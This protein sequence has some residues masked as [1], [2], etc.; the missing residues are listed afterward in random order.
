MTRKYNMKRRA[1]QQN[2]TRQRIVEATVELHETIGMHTS[3][4]AIAKKAGVQRLTVYK[5][6]PDEQAL[7]SA[8]SEHFMANNPPPDPT[9]WTHL[10]DP[11]ERL[12]VALSEVYAYHRRTEPMLSN[13]FRAAPE[14]PFLFELAQP[15]LQL[16]ERMRY[17]IAASWGVQ[18]QQPVLLLAA[19]A[20]ALDLQTWR[21]LVQQQGLTDKQAVELMVQLVQCTAGSGSTPP[22]R[23]HTAKPSTLL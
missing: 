3:I 15:Y 16:W 4:S 6:F 9:S 11:E 23:G 1:E 18:A 7:L 8:C 19:L 21:S 17:V 13:V 2:K 20:H 5:H 14:K 22:K 10:A 12:R